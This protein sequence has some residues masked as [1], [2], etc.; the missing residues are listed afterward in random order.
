MNGSCLVF[1]HLPSI[2]VPTFRY[3]P[4]TVI[5]PLLL[6]CFLQT[7]AQAARSD[8]SLVGSYFFQAGVCRSGSAVKASLPSSTHWS[9]QSS[10]PICYASCQQRLSRKLRTL[11]C[12]CSAP[13][14]SRPRIFKQLSQQHQLHSSCCSSAGLVTI[15]LIN[16][17]Q[18]SWYDYSLL[19][20]HMW[21]NH[22]N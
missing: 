18:F 22:F 21:Y 8:R 13:V 20:L 5:H 14:R 10:V 11:S 15:T 4:H 9:G 19:C 3:A 17:I 6:L 12:T 16:H 1:P 2:P 7:A